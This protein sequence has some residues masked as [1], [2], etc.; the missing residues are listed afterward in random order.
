MVVIN[1]IKQKNIEGAMMGLMKELEKLAP[2]PD[3]PDETGPQFVNI[4][5]QHKPAAEYEGMLGSMVLE[6]FLGTAFADAV[7]AQL[8]SCSQTFFNQVDLSMMAEAVSEYSQDRANASYNLGQKK[9]ISA[10]FNKRALWQQMM[11]AYLKDL[12]K[13]L[14]IERFLADYQRKLYALHKHTPAPA[15]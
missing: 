6:S 7:S 1:Q 9:A 3:R 2:H 4:D 11:D 12:P 8:G 13:R 15:A 14:G 10:Q 5:S